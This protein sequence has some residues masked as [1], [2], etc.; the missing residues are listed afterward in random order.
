M[1]WT[2]ASVAASPSRPHTRCRVVNEIQEAQVPETN[3]SMEDSS[4][5]HTPKRVDPD[6]ESS[7]AIE[8]E[9][10]IIYDDN[11]FQGLKVERSYYCF[12]HR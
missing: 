7:T 10:G 8:D 9:A 12:Y 4:P 11:Q 6:L 2:K 3:D 1:A 5:T